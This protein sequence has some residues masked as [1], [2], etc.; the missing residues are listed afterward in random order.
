M[1]AELLPF[2]M[3]TVNMFALEAAFDNDV[4]QHNITNQSYVGD[5]SIGREAP[6]RR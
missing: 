2:V 5:Q 3:L 1:F 4:F 6:D